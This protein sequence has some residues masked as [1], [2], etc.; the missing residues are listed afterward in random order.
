MVDFGMALIQCKASDLLWDLPRY[1]WGLVQHGQVP[2]GE[3]DLRTPH[4]GVYSKPG[5]M[6]VSKLTY[7]TG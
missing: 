3:G 6:T 1:L 7:G 2:A 4:Q 5:H